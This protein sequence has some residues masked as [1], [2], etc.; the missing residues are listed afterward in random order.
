[1]SLVSRDNDIG[2][3]LCIHTRYASVR[4]ANNA[5]SNNNKRAN[6]DFPIIEAVCAR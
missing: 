6:K 2:M 3:N 5:Q 1:M 4:L